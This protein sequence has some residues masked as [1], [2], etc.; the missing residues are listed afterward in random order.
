MTYQTIR[1][2]IDEG[3]AVLT[4]NRPDKLNSFTMAMHRE[5]KRALAEVSE[6]GA[7]ALVITGE[8]RGFCAGQDLTDPEVAADGPQD[9]GA[10]LEEHYNPLILGLRNMPI[11]VIAAVNGV[12]AGAGMSLALACDIVLAARSASFLQAF[13][14]IGLI[15]DA[16]STYFLSRALGESRAKALAMLGEPIKAETAFQWGLVWQ[17]VDDDRLNEEARIL[18]GRLAGGATKAL[19]LT[20][21][22]MHAASTNSIEQQLDL[23]RDFQSQ[24]GR[25]ADFAEGVRAFVE[26]RPARFT[27][28]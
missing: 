16:G 15:P 1:L 14:R 22:A 24:A 7:R 8:G 23:E 25:T 18:G 11:P 21:Q 3:L 27:G 12:A 17:V 20:K 5:L 28:S 6:S 13:S 26:K 9:T 10:A 2:E 4:L 19:A